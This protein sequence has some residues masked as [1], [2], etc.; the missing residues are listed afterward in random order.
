[1]QMMLRRTHYMNKRKEK[2]AEIDKTQAM[3][4][5]MIEQTLT[6]CNQ[7][8][9]AELPPNFVFAMGDSLTVMKNFVRDIETHIAISN[10][11]FQYK[12]SED[13]AKVSSDRKPFEFNCRAKKGRKRTRHNK[14]ASSM[15]N[16]S[17][18]L[19]VNGSL[20]S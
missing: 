1:M 10:R 5:A 14:R 8:P 2:R 6:R 15:S 18:R 4:K 9:I 3:V 11:Y 16:S 20:R 17:T 13:R 12:S 7:K 19:S